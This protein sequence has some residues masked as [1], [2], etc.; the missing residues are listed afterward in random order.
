MSLLG[1]ADITIAYGAA[2]VVRALSF[3]LESGKFIAIVGPSGCGKSSLL[4]CIAGL[5]R[6]RSGVVVLD[7]RDVWAMSDRHRSALRANEIGFL[8]QDYV[9]D[10]TRSVLDNVMEPISY[11][12]RARRPGASER[13]H[14]LIDELG[15][16]VPIGRRPGEIS[17]GQAQRIALCRALIGNPRLLLADE[18]TGSLDRETGAVVAETLRGALLAPETRLAAVVA[19]THD[20]RFAAA[21]D[22][23]YQLSTIDGRTHL[24]EVV[25]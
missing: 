1:L 9:L 21:A 6:P 25:Y 18:P 3:G 19:V 17:G 14:Q 7:G 10:P 13:A 4:Y 16:N 24:K 8:F 11:A 23:V 15:V 5:L 22:C 12:D 20:D 2:P